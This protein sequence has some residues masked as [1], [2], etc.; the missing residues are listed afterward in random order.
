ME[1]DGPE[2]ILIDVEALDSRFKRGPGE[3]QAGCGA[4]RTGDASV[5]LGK[6]ALDHFFFFN[7]QGG[8]SDGRGC[9]SGCGLHQPAL[10]HG[11]RSSL[12]ENDGSFDY[13]LQFA[14]ISRPMV[15]LE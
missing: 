3:A 4:T 12:G 6:S 11:K 8:E 13:I 15:G 14:N 7:G 10:I 2:A 1:L 5:A 9:R